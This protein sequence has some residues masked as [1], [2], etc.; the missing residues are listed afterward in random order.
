[1]NPKQPTDKAVPM[2]IEPT[3][4]GRF[5]FLW[6]QTHIP[7]SD[8]TCLAAPSCSLRGHAIVSLHPVV[9]FFCSFC[10]SFWWGSSHSL[11]GKFSP[12]SSS[13]DLPLLFLLADISWIISWFQALFQTLFN[14]W[15]LIWLSQLCGNT[16]IVV[17]ILKMRNQGPEKLNELSVRS[18][19]RQMSFSVWS[20]AD[21]PRQS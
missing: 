9:C 6:P 7:S 3:L 5:L 8:P 10:S 20:F 18:Q 13:S 17:S 4:Q 19:P 16:S 12:S 11:G 2:S 15:K 21:I 14:T 1:M